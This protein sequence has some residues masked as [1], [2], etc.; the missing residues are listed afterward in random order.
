MPHQT[1]KRPDSDLK[2]KSMTC[3]GPD[4]GL[5]FFDR[6]GSGLAKPSSVQPIPTSLWHQEPTEGAECR[7]SE[8]SINSLIYLSYIINNFF[9]CKTT[10][11]FSFQHKINFT[12]KFCKMVLII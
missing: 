2:D 10:H 7:D 9:F 8:A 12:S 5:Q 3:H 1:F 4:S 11:N 6:P